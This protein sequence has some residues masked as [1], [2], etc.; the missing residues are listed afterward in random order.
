MEDLYGLLS[1]ITMS[2]DNDYLDEYDIKEMGKDRRKR[3]KVY[4]PDNDKY[5]RWEYDLSYVRGFSV[6]IYS[7][8]IPYGTQRW[9]VDEHDIPYEISS[10]SSKTV[11]HAIA[12]SVSEYDADREIVSKTDSGEYR[13]LR[14]TAAQD[15]V[16]T[17]ARSLANVKLRIQDGK[18]A[19]KVFYNN[20]AIIE[21]KAKDKRIKEQVKS[22]VN[23]Y[24]KGIK[25]VGSK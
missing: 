20:N 7:Y 3:E 1:N 19:Y 15:G 8:D 17:K 11:A 4:Q 23:K 9:G 12:K 10:V 25:R 18:I 22:E 6:H 16:P 14:I 21:L 2:D 13:W 24:I 5:E